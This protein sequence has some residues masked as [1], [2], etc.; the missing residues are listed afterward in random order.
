M[1]LGEQRVRWFMAFDLFGIQFNQITD[2]IV[3]GL[4]AWLLEVFLYLNVSFI[5]VRICCVSLS[6]LYCIFAARRGE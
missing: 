3:I 2:C 1:H 5:F 4:C 6:V